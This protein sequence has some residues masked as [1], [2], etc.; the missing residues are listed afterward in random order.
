MVKS[1]N[2]SFIKDILD[3]IED[4]GKVK[5]ASFFARGKK[6]PNS[7]SVSSL[8][9]AS[10]DL[11]M[12]FPVLCDNTIDPRTASM[13]CKAV[14]RKA[15]TMLQ[16][17]FA[18][19]SFTQIADGKSVLK[20]W[21]TNIDGGDLSLD[22]Y[23]DLVDKYTME[24]VESL[25][26]KDRRSIHLLEQT[27]LEEHA[28]GMGSPY[29]LDSISETS[30]NDYMVN[31]RYGK[32][33]V[34]EAKKKAPK[35]N[36]NSSSIQ[37]APP[38]TGD[39]MY[40]GPIDPNN[41]EDNELD[42]R[43]SL[44]TNFNNYKNRYNTAIKNQMDADD[45]EYQRQYQSYRDDIRD[46]QWGTDF[47][48]RKAQAA[49][50]KQRDASRDAYQAQQDAIRNQQAADNLQFQKDKWEDEKNRNS[51]RDRLDRDRFDMAKSDQERNNMQRMLLDNDIKKCNEL[52]PSL[53]IV[54]FRDQN[55]NEKHFVAGVKARLIGVDSYDIADRVYS[56]NKDRAGLV[57]L[58]R[59]TTKEIS[60][61]KDYLLAIDR[62]KIDAK[63]NSVKNHSGRIWKTL[64]K[65]ST[66]SVWKRMTGQTNDAAAITTLVV[67]QQLVNL[68]KKEYDVDLA[69]VKTAS[70]IMDSYNLLCLCIVDESMEVARFLY[71][72]DSY[73]E[74]LSFNSLERET[75]DGSYKKVINLLSKM[76]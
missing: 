27:V 65:R 8:S 41:L 3:A 9:R 10:K 17:I 25:P 69:N 73:Y 57:N 19:C 33:V 14:E 66:R 34:M 53:M 28:N 6:D 60:F 59:A 49:Y 12:S 4:I 23:L 7:M 21:H 32:I 50:Q 52:V 74:D 1:I 42:I 75:G 62:A 26:V 70:M 15:V 71:D 35:Y 2:E 58:I 29:K 48:A 16:L 51:A 44:D 31:P 47:A 76:K 45:A 38:L 72:G 68:I 30:I 24:S 20:Q 67:S 11:V 43:K 56:K 64:E 39:Q 22:D 54:T 46:K 18:S 5:D 13:I 61:V 37:Y 55:N 36:S 40:G 63:R